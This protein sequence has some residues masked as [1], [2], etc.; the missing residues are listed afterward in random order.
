MG[1]SKLEEPTHREYKLVVFGTG[2]VG[3]SAL[4]C[5]YVQGLFLQKYD[6]TIED[7]YR[8]VTSIEGRQYVLE[9][10]DTAGTEQFT[11]MR[12]LY[13][14]EGNGFIFV[15]SVTAQS[16]FL[17]LEGMIE[18]LTLVRDCEHVPKLIVGN[19]SDLES[20]RVIATEQGEELA[21][22][23]GADFIECSA[24]TRH[25]V[26]ELFEHIVQQIDLNPPKKE[27]KRRSPKC[28]IL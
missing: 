26:D 19:K 22:D 4:T 13:M 14:R 27:I 9:I 3:K 2:G 15:Y 5:Q 10:L 18:K 8:K 20:Q 1:F 28:A 16:T 25:N 17:A 12:D 21:R 11:A 7:A 24:K 6:P 23:L